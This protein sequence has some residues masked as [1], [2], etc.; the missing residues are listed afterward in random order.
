MPPFTSNQ[1]LQP[2]PLMARR[3]FGI[4]LFNLQMEQLDIILPELCY[5]MPVTEHRLIVQIINF[6]TFGNHFVCPILRIFYAIMGFFL[7]QIIHKPKPSVDY[8]ILWRA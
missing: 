7:H 6:G 8:V 5:K 4:F 3:G 1:G 2:L